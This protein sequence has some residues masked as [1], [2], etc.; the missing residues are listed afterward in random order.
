VTLPKAHELRIDY[1][2]TKIQQ[3][4][5]F[6]SDEITRSV[7]T[8]IVVDQSI[9]FLPFQLG[10]TLPKLDKIVVDRSNLTA[11]QK[12]DFKGLTELRHIEIR[13]N[14]L[15]SIGDETFDDV[16]QIESLDL[17]SNNIRSLP[18]KIFLH[19]VHLKSLILSNNQIEKF[20]A[21]LMPRKNAIE[22]FQVNNNELDLIETKILRYLRRAKI[23]DLSGNICIDLKY[24]KT[25]NNSKA[26]VELSGEI[27]LNCSSDD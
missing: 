21:D 11:L 9:K 17:S 16:T 12:H 1:P 5:G 27:D 18:S 15:T 6:D 14:N 19:L 3:V 22:V 26:L 2:K 25:E 8:F 20:T 10:Q 13:H 4:V 23:I 24:E 7:K